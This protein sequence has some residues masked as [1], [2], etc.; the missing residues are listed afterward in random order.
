VYSS[1]QRCEFSNPRNGGACPILTHALRTFARAARARCFL[2][3]IKHCIIFR[4]SG[5]KTEEE[6]QGSAALEGVYGQLVASI[7]EV[8]Q[9]FR[10][11]M[12]QGG[13]TETD[14]LANTLK[15]ITAIDLTMGECHCA[16]LRLFSH[17]QGDAAFCEMGLGVFP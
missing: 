1:S 11:Q 6:K 14:P 5:G 16:T 7:S 10:E 8:R 4:Q 2:S 9:P 17:L 12:L 15:K 3:D 13:Q